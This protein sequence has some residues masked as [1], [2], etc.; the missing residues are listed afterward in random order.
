MFEREAC[1]AALDAFVSSFE[2]EKKSW[3]YDLVGAKAEDQFIFT[4]SYAAA[5]NQVFHSVYLEKAR[6]EGKCHIVISDLASAAVKLC[7]KRCEELGCTIKIAP[8]G[9]NGQIDVEGLLNL[10][11]ALISVPIADE[12]T[13]VMQPIEEIEKLAREGG[14]LLHLDGL[15]A[16]GKCPMQ[17]TSDYLTFSGE[18][19][20]S[21]KSS[22]GLFV[23]GQ[24]PLIPFCLGESLD[25]ASFMAL[26]AAAQQAVFFLDSVMMETAR[27]RNLF[28]SALQEEVVYANAQRLPH[29]SALRFR[30]VHPETLFYFLQRKKIQAALSGDIVSFSFSR[31]TTEEEVLAAVQTIRSICAELYLL[32]EAL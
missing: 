16:V 28:E 7:A 31:M 18:E 2:E 8:V 25:K 17:F 13:G 32:S 15:A 24:A 26:M 14:I 11:T 19:I 6:K 30:R 12:I 4:S 29:L 10:K 23:K 9:S 21:V 27:L 22:G 20:H 1:K 5:V 3:I